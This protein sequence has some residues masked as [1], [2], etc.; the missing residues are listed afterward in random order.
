MEAHNLMVTCL[1]W[2]LDIYQPYKR[3]V[4]ITDN[5]ASCLIINI[6]Y[7]DYATLARAVANLCANLCAGDWNQKSTN[8]YLLD[9]ILN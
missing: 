1:F 4:Y 5:I 6:N 9:V 8:I 7:L 3:S 2:Q